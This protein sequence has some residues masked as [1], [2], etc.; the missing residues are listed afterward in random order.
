MTVCAAAS[1]WRFAG[2]T[3]TLKRG[4]LQVTRS[5]EVIGPSELRF[6]Q[7]KTAKSTRTVPLPSQAVAALKRHRAAQVEWMMR[8]RDIRA[9]N[10]LVFPW[11]DGTPWHPKRFSAAFFRRMKQLRVNVSFHGLR[12]SYA[13]ILLRAGTP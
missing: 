12:H 4:A 1:F 8:H 5:L 9:D 3:S 11:L 2:R 7:P 13:S 6:K 10:D